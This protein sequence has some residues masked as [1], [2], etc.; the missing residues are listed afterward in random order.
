M[1]RIET[2]LDTVKSDIGNFYKVDLHHFI[3]MNIVDLGEKLE[4]QWFFADYAQP[5]DVTMFVTQMDPS[6]QIPSICNSVVSAWAA[7]AELVDLMGVNIENAK[8]GFVL[9]D[10]FEGAPLRKKQ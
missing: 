6:V 10:D 5:C 4:V 3:V 1:K 7:E 8:K 9:E 2:T